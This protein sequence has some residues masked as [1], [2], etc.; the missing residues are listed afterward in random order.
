MKESERLARASLCLKTERREVAD[1]L[2][3]IA[4]SYWTV[5]KDKNRRIIKARKNGDSSLSVGVI[6]PSV[7][8]APGTD[9]KIIVRWRFYENPYS[10]INLANKESRRYAKDMPRKRNGFTDEKT[11]LSKAQDW[12]HALIRDALNQ[13]APLI[14]EANGLH[15]AIKKIAVSTRAI[16]K[17]S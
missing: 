15:E 8:E 13:M 12:E 3:R 6:A 11:L 10:R 7:R 5:W 14:H 4:D 1:Q 9:G 16:K 2:S 17:L